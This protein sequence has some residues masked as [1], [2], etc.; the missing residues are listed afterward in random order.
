MFKVIVRI[1]GR[2]QRHGGAEG[3]VNPKAFVDVTTYAD[4][5]ADGSADMKSWKK[6]YMTGYSDKG[7]FYAPEFDNVFYKITDIVAI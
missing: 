2:Y 7:K 1:W 6:K 3:R 4:M 5:K